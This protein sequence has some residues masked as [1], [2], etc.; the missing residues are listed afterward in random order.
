MLRSWTASHAS[1]ALSNLLDR[2]AGLWRFSK[3]LVTL[4]RQSPRRR[5]LRDFKRRKQFILIGHSMGTLLSIA[6][7]EVDDLH[8]LQG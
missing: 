2:S 1:K 4:R 6:Y 3:A 8:N 7:V 5:T